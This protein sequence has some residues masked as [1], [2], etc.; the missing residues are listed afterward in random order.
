[1]TRIAGV[2]IVVIGPTVVMALLAG[3]V[4][5]IYRTKC[6]DGCDVAGQFDTSRPLGWG[7]LLT[8]I[9]LVVSVVTLVGLPRI[10]R[11]RVW[12]P[13]VPTYMVLGVSI[14]AV[15]GAVALTAAPATWSP[16]DQQIRAL[17]TVFFVLLLAFSAT[18]VLALRLP[19]PA[20][21]DLAAGVAAG[22][23]VQRPPMTENENR[24]DGEI[25]PYMETANAP[26]TSAGSEA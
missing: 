12:M 1:M 2:I 20:P 3:A 17:L 19:A 11:Y 25:A 13:V 22:V 15:V 26:Q 7:L 9:L 24:G 10:V 23:S 18:S 14:I 4:I 8:G 16:S 6:M 5:D 21:A